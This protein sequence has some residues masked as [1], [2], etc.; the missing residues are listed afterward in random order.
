M[1]RLG[2]IA[3]IVIAATFVASAGGGTAKTD[4]STR[5]G[6]VSYLVQH[7]I[8]PTGVVIQRGARNYAGPTCPGRGWTCTK[9]A[10]VV[11]ISSGSDNQFQCVASSGTP[12]V[13]PNSCTIVQLSSGARNDARCY[14][15]TG[16]PGVTQSCTIQQ[17]NTTGDNRSDVQQSVNVGDAAATDV[18][19]FANV[20]QENG[21][22]SNASQLQQNIQQSSKDPDSTGV[23]SQE[24][25]QTADVTQDSA[26]GGN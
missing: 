8:D 7:G 11:Q 16:D 23:Q 1:K 10:R 2:V 12:A 5:P 24:G 4:L 14:E 6:V 18:S 25:H 3:A 9:A 15:R 20:S 21:S 17:T 19:Q 26:T 22:G 13:A